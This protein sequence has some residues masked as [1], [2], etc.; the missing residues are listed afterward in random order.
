MG[1]IVVKIYE[2]MKLSK[3]ETEKRKNWKMINSTPICQN[4][5]KVL[6][7]NVINLFLHFIQIIILQ[8]RKQIKNEPIIREKHFLG[9]EQRKYNGSSN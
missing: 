5:R 4:S 7:K 8:M 9:S 1:D 6:S 3:R 2:I